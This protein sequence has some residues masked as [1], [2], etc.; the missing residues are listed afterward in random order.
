MK[1]MSIAGAVLCALGIAAAQDV[2]DSRSSAAQG[3]NSMFTKPSDA[4]LRRALAPLSYSVT[5]KNA[6]EPPFQNAFWDNKKPGLYV[7]IVSGEP[8]FNSIDK[9]DSGCGWPSFT[10]PVSGAT[11]TQK[12][13][14]TQGMSRVEVRSTRADSHLGH[15][16]ND[17][18]APGGLRYCINSAS[19]RFVPLEK[20]AAEG[21]AAQ[22]EPFVK[23]GLYTLSTNETAA[24]QSGGTNRQ[25]ATFAGGCFWGMEEILRKIPGVL[26]TR[27]GYTGGTTPTPT[28]EMVCSGSTGHAEAVEIAFDPDKISYEQ[29]L[30]YFF[31]MHDPT[32]LNR[33]HNDVG[34][35]YRSAI[36]YHSD[37]QRKAAEHARTT[38]DKSGKWPK[39]V[40]TEIVKATP[41]YE[42]EEYHQSY[43]QK[44][45]NGYTCHYLR[46]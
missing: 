17:G 32:T 1:L 46:D 33:Q 13:D 12:M 5:Q 39:P 10:K 31:R 30:G 18:P 40:V 44:H 41:F 9:F 25:I 8:L 28:Y 37:A 29:L 11:L 34:T 7:D 4:Q 19:L 23:A 38:L 6:T 16:F 2:V 26:H 22:L 42:A 3:T 14:L 36:F 27:V 35:Q 20:M 43:L 21:F 24:I 45:P 15:V